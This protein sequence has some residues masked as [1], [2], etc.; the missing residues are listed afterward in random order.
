[1]ILDNT[2]F[3]D[4][5]SNLIDHPSPIHIARM[6]KAVVLGAAGKSIIYDVFGLGTYPK[7]RRYRATLSS[8]A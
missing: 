7:H 6:V 2:A 4:S 3:I 8:A 5:L 1:V